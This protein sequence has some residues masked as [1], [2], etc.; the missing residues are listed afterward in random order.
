MIFNELTRTCPLAYKNLMGNYAYQ[1]EDYLSVLPEMR[2]IYPE[3]WEEIALD[4]DVIKLEPDYKNYEKLAKAGL[5]HVVTMRVEGV[6]AGYHISIVAPHLHYASSMT[7][8][9]DIF[10]VRKVH[11]VGLRGYFLLKFMRDSLFARG[12]QRIYMATKLHLDLDPLIKRLGGR[13]VERLYT[14][15]K[16]NADVCNEAPA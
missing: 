3:H 9:T 14:I 13:P 16:R 12:V 4:R 6:L 11:R 7:A 5:L 8:F 15:T 1:V 2:E 10:F